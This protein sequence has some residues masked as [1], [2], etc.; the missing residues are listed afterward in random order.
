V[1]D[2]ERYLW[3]AV[4]TAGAVVVLSAATRPEPL[5]SS[6][7]FFWW[8]WLTIVATALALTLYLL[9]LLIEKLFKKRVSG[10]LLWLAF[11]GFCAVVLLKNLGATANLLR[12]G[13]IPSPGWSSTLAFLFMAIAI[14]TTT[15]WGRSHGWLCRAASFVALSVFV[16]S[17]WPKPTAPG[18]ASQLP[19]IQLSAQRLL[20]IG[21][22]GAD[23]RYIDL[24]I[25]RGELPNLQ[26]LIETGV[27]AP[28]ATIQPTRSPALW[29]TMVTGK[30][31]AAH[32]VRGHAVLRARNGRH[33]MPKPG[34]MPKGFGI[35]SIFDL[36][37][38]K[39]YIVTSPSTS[40][41]RRVP[42]FW[43]ITTAYGSPL[44][45][46]NWW[47]TWPAEAILGRMVTDRTYFWRW[48]S[49]GYGAV[50][51]AITFPESLYRQLAPMVMRPD[52]VALADAR[53]FMDIDD[54]E[55]AASRDTAY[56]HHELLSEFRYYYSMFET[57]RRF[58][59]YFFER[60]AVEGVQASD[61]MVIFRLVDMLSHSSLQYSEL[62][63]DHLQRTPEEVR[64]F[65]QAVSE[66]YRQVDRAIGEMTT[67]FGQSNVVVVSDHGFKL[68]RRRR[69]KAYDHKSGPS[70]I[71]LAAGPAFT[72]GRV[73]ELSIYQVFPILLA[74]K[75]LPVPADIARQLP[76]QV[77]AREF[78]RQ[79][80]VSSI[81]SY[82]SLE[83][84]N[85]T[86]ESAVDEEMIERLRA[87]GYLD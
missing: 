84:R 86:G 4:L 51:E 45:V 70:G 8:R 29:T 76:T 17:I 67:A 61:L 18:Q 47:A 14:F 12:M 55:F 23:W 85:G 80:P 34:A 60:A 19:E 37:Y 41:E 46:V 27:R 77:L 30:R 54:D 68:E 66:A 64:R 38:R 33:S 82:G 65:G 2:L 36:L 42:A 69:L 31:P 3:L 87:L 7:A 20:V 50:D 9:G 53:R 1:K 10:A 21:L 16:L 58:V 39:G 81:E 59:S 72:E 52:E 28:L 15:A 6:A 44:D 24:L 22:D 78:L 32:G 73:E 74:V 5:E 48:A 13:E 57:H 35:K 26:Q 79:H 40:L 71:F 49:R 25:E 62:V 43:N 56:R 63:E 75:G 83:T 11:L